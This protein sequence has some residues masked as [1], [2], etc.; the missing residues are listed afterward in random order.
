[1]N[2]LEISN[3]KAKERTGKSWPEWFRVLDTWNA[4]KHGHKETAKRLTEKFKLG[5]WWAQVVTIR[6]EKERG[7]WVKSYK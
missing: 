3:E 7:Y 5:S 1:M 2:Y 6:Y 4:K